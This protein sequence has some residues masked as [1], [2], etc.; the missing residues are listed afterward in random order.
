MNF[1]KRFCVLSVMMLVAVAMMAQELPKVYILAT[2]GTIAGSGSSATK[3]NYSAGQVAIGTLLDAVPA[4]N[5]VAYIEGEQ[6]VNIGSQDMSDDVRN[7]LT[8]K[9]DEE[10]EGIKLGGL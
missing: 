6:V 10:G 2:G 5:D 7:R 9:Y 3:S 4:I 1:L 8:P